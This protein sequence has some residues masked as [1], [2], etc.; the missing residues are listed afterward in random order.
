MT[1]TTIIAEAG[2]N[3]NGSVD[4]AHRLVDLAKDCGADIIKFQ[5]FST[6]LLVRSDAP[7]VAYQRRSGADT[8]FDLVKPLELT[9]EEFAALERH[10]KAADIEFLSTAFDG[11][12]LDYLVDD[13]GMKRVKI[14]SGEAVNVPLLRRAGAK[15]VP[16][17][18]STGM[19]TLEEI[20]FALATLRSSAPS[21][22]VD[23]TVLHC[24]TAY[25]TPTN[26]I[27]LR[28]ML[29]IRDRFDVPVGLSDH[30]DGFWAAAAAVAMGASVVEKH[31][32]LDR[33]LPGPD[34]RASVDPK[35]LTTLIEAIRRIE[36]MLGSAV[37]GVRA[38]EGEAVRAVRRSLVAARDIR[39]GELICESDLVA[40]RPDDGISAR[41]ID[42][43]VG[44]AAW[45]EFRR[46]EVL[47]WPE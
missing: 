41:D 6:E 43:V 12:S 45:R 8:M 7:L 26:E 36:S 44:V 18:L 27:H 15:G 13:L 30:S 34:H 20:D 46:G 3:H 2:V 21:G 35:G 37:K 14:P 28:S 33:D 40:L 5:T 32:T 38:I 16:I 9:K 1:R 23:A 19:C 10:C 24:T 22:E 29:T 39:A 4:I 42:R 25:P 31:F 11:A 17:I 47:K